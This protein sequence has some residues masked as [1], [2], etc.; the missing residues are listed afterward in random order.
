M[1]FLT[2]SSSIIPTNE[3]I[4]K[5]IVLSILISAVLAAPASLLAQAQRTGFVNSA[6][7]FQ[8]LPEAQD[9]QKRIDAITKPV[10][11]TLLSLRK[12]LETRYEEY[13]KKE[14]LMTESAKRTAQQEFA[15]LQRRAQDYA[16]AKDQELAA[17]KDK[18]L[19]PITEKVMVAIQ[20]VA[21]EEKYNFVFDRTET[22]R[23]LIYGDPKDDLTNRVIDKLKRGK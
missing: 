11:D 15:D 4:V 5:N 12:E 17:Q 3:V 7:I 13:Q 1:L 16:Q 2:I 8:E 23:V 19:A 21:K 6:K 20:K 22:V 18:I 10:Q 9:A 14:A